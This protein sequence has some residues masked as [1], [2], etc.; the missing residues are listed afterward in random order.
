MRAA[1]LGWGYSFHWGME[2]RGLPFDTDHILGFYI[3]ISI[4]TNKCNVMEIRDGLE[5]PYTIVMVFL[6]L[7]IWGNLHSII[8]EVNNYEII[9]WFHQGGRKIRYWI[10]GMKLTTTSLLH[11]TIFQTIETN[12]SPFHPFQ[13][14]NINQL[15][16]VSTMFEEWKL[17][18]FH[19]IP[20]R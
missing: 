16:L 3:D 15:T 10:D 1:Y 11:S 19:S 6:F 18:S 9:S 13:I 4:S 17:M 12:I 5:L 2:G 14:I 20:F 7:E 8:W